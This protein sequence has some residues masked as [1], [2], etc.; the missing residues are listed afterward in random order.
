M[1]NAVVVDSIGESLHNRALTHQLTE[2]LRP[3]PQVKR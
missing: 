1:G 2:G 3:V